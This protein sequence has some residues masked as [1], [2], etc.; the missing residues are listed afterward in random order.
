MTVEEIINILKEYP[1]D[2]RVLVDWYE[3]GY[4]NPD[5]IE[6]VEVY[7]RGKGGYS[8]EYESTDYLYEEETV[9][10]FIAVIIPR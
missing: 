4:D 9:A 1:P 8:G 10:R 3:S 6:V 7:D 2:M 5:K